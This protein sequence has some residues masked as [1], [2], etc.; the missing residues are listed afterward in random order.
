M[1]VVT[2]LSFRLSFNVLKIYNYVNMIN[3]GVT[4]H[5]KQEL[6]QRMQNCNLLESDLEEKFIR[7]GGPGGQKVNKAST[8]VY[9][10]HI[11]TGLTVKVQTSRSQQLNRY[12]A[13]KQLCEMIENEMLGNNSPSAKK[14]EK[15]RKQKNRRRRR[16]QKTAQSQPLDTMNQET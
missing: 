10:K 15:I 6:I 14:I 13:R 2:F 11:P 4:E 9:L 1:K 12:Y 8:C 16:H 3:F 7:S 5:K